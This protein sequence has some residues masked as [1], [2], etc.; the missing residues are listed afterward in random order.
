[1]DLCK[2]VVLNESKLNF[3]GQISFD[4]LAE[5]AVL[6]RHNETNT[7]QVGCDGSFWLKSRRSHVNVHHQGS[8]PSGPVHHLL[9]FSLSLS[10]T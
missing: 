7:D 2:A 3:D 1:M 5:I 10:S 9:L 4:A 6:S 8:I